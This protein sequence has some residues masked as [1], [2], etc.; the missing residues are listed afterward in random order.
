VVC[1]LI[2][3]VVAAR[4][5]VDRRE[6]W[7]AAGFHAGLFVLLIGVGGVKG[8]YAEGTR[9]VSVEAAS[10]VPEALL[11]GLLWSF[12][13]VLAVTFLLRVRGGGQGQGGWGGPPGY[14]PGHLPAYPPAYGQP[15]YGQPVPGQPVPGQPAYGQPV[16]GQQSY[17]QPGDGHPQAQDQPTQEPQAQDQPAPGP[18]AP[19][20]QSHAPQVSQGWTHDAPSAGGFGEPELLLNLNAPSEKPPRAPRNRLLLVG[21]IMLGAFAIGGAATAGVIMYDRND[22][23]PADPGSSTSSPAVPGDQDSP[24]DSTTESPSDSATESPSDAVTS[25]PFDNPTDT[26][27]ATATA[28]ATDDPAGSVSDDPAALP[29][30]SV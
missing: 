24:S 23:K 8:E 9:S 18:H 17:P 16:P 21:L 15:G 12:G 10:S 27:T 25:D 26:P 30:G 1:A 19:S 14:P 20:P 5:C 28:T 3:G 2:L 11:F 22:D 4:C 13:G 29:S 6:Q 7:L